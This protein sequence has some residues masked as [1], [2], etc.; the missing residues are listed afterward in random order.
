[1]VRL[2]FLVVPIP[3]SGTVDRSKVYE[4]LLY[5]KVY[6]RDLASLLALL[7]DTVLYSQ[8]RK[9][10]TKHSPEGTARNAIVED[11]YGDFGKGEVE[12]V[13]ESTQSLDWSSS[14]S[15]VARFEKVSIVSLQAMT[16]GRLLLTTHGLYFIQTGNV[17][18]V[19]TRKRL[20]WSQRA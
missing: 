10:E 6:G 9:N 7:S 12:K 16:E 11:D 20:M 8:H 5:S 15:V 17:V 19:M 18:S 1:V 2:T 14:E 3:N 13:A 4:V